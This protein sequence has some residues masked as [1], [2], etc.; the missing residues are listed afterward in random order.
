VMSYE[1]DNH[2]SDVP[3][4]VKAGDLVTIIPRTR[5]AEAIGEYKPEIGVILTTPQELQD[6]VSVYT[7]DKG[8][9]TVAPNQWYFRKLSI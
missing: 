3:L 5:W 7:F 2:E 8:M 1:E 4:L 6:Y 9:W